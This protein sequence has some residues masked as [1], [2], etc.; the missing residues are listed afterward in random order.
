[1][2]QIRIFHQ[3]FRVRIYGGNERRLGTYKCHGGWVSTGNSGR[4]YGVGD[5]AII[6]PVVRHVIMRESSGG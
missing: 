3:G 5:Q 6:A 2:A 1:M 4:R